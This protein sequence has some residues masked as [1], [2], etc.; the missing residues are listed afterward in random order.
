MND[1][2]RGGLRPGEIHGDASRNSGADVPRWRASCKVCHHPRR[3]DIDKEILAATASKAEIARK[4]AVAYQ[5]VWYHA[6][7]GQ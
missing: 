1:S 5:S 3:F 7:A 2:R 4:Y 6:K